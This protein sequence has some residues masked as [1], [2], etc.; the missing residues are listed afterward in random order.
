MCCCVEIKEKKKLLNI[1]LCLKSNHTDGK[2]HTLEI[3]KTS[4]NGYLNKWYFKLRPYYYFRLTNVPVLHSG[5]FNPL[6]SNSDKNGVSLY[7]ITT[8]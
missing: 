6:N 2:Q 1:K 4:L 8:C 7:V 5:E 3:G